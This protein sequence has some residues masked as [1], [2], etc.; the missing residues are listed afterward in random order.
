M[1]RMMWIGMILALGGGFDV[2]VAADPASE[3]NTGLKVGEKAPDFKLKDQNGE[4][5]TLKDLTKDG[6]V[7]LV[8]YRS[9]SW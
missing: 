6:S 8:F 9:A 4:E 5:R 7:A 1:I 2:A 3:N